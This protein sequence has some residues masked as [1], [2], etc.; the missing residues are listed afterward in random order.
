MFMGSKTQFLVLL[1]DH[2]A[3]DQYKFLFTIYSTLN[4]YLK[5]STF[6]SFT[7]FVL[8]FIVSQWQIFS[9]YCVLIYRLTVMTYYPRLQVCSSE[10]S[11]IPNYS[12]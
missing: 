5:Y 4:I 3:V 8:I 2:F 9:R 7:K 12:I 10:L 1:T 6:H 11:D